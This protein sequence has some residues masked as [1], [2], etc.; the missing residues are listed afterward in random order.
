M[1]YNL[2]IYQTGTISHCR[3]STTYLTYHFLILYSQ[4]R[5]SDSFDLLITC[6]SYH[7]LILH[8]QGMYGGL[9][10]LFVVTRH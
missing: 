8:S 1:V 5:Y 6:H 4:G 9:F 10:D 3:W 7:F 2:F